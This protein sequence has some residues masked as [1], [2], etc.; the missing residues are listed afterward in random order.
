MDILHE[1]CLI[2]F[3]FPADDRVFAAHIG[4]SERRLGFDLDDV[5]MFWAAD[6]RSVLLDFY[7]DRLGMT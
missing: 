6:S 7:G 3:L 4:L 2:R 5:A 1:L